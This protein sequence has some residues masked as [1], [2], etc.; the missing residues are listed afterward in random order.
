MLTGAGDDRLPAYTYRLCLSTD[1][2]NQDPLAGPPPG[3]DR[4]TYTGYFDDLEA[5]RLAGPKVLKPGRGYYPRHFDTLVRAL[6]VAEI[7][8]RK[9]DVNINPRP[10]GFPFAE[11]NAGYVEGDILDPEDRG[12]DFWVFRTDASGGLLWEKVFDR[13]TYDRAYSVRQTT[14]GGYIVAGGSTTDT[15]GVDFGDM[16][17]LKLDSAGGKEWELTLGGDS[18]E[19]A[20]AVLQAPDGG[21]I[22]AG[23]TYSYGAGSSDILLVKISR[24]GY[25]ELDF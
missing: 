6:S 22:V 11:E 3:Y 25:A 21:Y 9:T 14:D 15:W 13:G 16:L 4:R 8:N 7:P 20:Y 12:S 23:N 24:D 18:I 19:N 5:G 1:P 2:A 17:A 10:L